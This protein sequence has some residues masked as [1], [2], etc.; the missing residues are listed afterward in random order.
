MS[1]LEMSDGCVQVPISASWLS[2][3]GASA[4]AV[5]PVISTPY[6]RVLSM[7]VFVVLKLESGSERSK[8]IEQ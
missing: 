1:Q 7:L 2:H 4:V 3:I 8:Y 6:S 5:V